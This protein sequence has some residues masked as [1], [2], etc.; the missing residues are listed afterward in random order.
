MPTCTAQDEA[1]H[2][3]EAVALHERRV[4]QAVRRVLG[5]HAVEEDDIVQETFA[6]LVVRLRQPGEVNVPA[7][8]C[9]VAHNL[10]VDEARRRRPLPV[11]ALRL[12]E[13]S[14]DPDPD[15]QVLA[16]ELADTLVLAL[17]RLSPGQR[18]VLMG[19]LETEPARGARLASALGVSV[20]AAESQLVRARRRLRRELATLGVETGAASKRVLVGVSATGTGLLAALVLTARW[21]GRGA[22]RAGAGASRAGTSLARVAVGAARAATSGGGPAAGAALGAKVGTVALVGGLAIGVLAIPSPG[23]QVGLRQGPE[24]HPIAH[25]VQDP[26]DQRAP[27][28][29]PGGSA[30]SDQPAP[31]T[32]TG[33]STPT[34]AAPSSGPVTSAPTP[35][36]AP[37]PR[38]GWPVAQALP[39][40]LQGALSSPTPLLAASTG[41]APAGTP[42]AVVAPAGLQVTASFSVSI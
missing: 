28:A 8:L 36:S 15:D 5:W 18:A 2:L 39:G 31:S 40:A 11:E 38:P 21:I 10:A 9:R 29:S 16:G 6:R 17:G 42:G 37:S 23:T 12:D 32:S 34:A 4:R 35:T 13:P 33:S 30:G 24:A 22:R 3:S 26:L 27:S 14:R 7:W 19:Q 41:A 1:T 20:H 25:Q